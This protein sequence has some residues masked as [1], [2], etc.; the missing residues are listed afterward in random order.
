[1]RLTINRP[2]FAAAWQQVAPIARP[3]VKPILGNVLLDN[4]GR[5]SLTATDMET[6]VE[7]DI[8]GCITSRNAT[9]GKVL[10]PADR[11]AAVLREC[12]DT[13][14][15]LD[16][17]PGKGVRIKTSRSKFDFPTMAPDEFPSMPTLEQD[18]YHTVAARQLLGALKRTAFACDE[19]SAR[20]AFGGVL[21]EWRDEHI[22][23]VATD[24]RRLC[25]DRCPAQGHDH[26]PKATTIVPSNVVRSIMALLDTE[27]DATVRADSNRF[28]VSVGD[29][30]LTTRLLEGRFPRWTDV[31]PKH[32]ADPIPLPVGGLAGA[33]AQ[34]AICTT[35]D[36]RSVDFA[37]ADGKLTLSA[38]TADVGQSSVEL[39]VPWDRKP[40]TVCL[41]HRFVSDLLR[42]LPSSDNVLLSI[43][44][45][46]GPT[47]WRYGAAECVIMPLARE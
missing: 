45:A 47:L 38:T 31:V 13:E 2:K 9:C 4:N 15:T 8:D 33:I 29:T 44:D 28:A 11:V 23:L 10:L 3:G 18:G 6:A 37:F 7:A 43:E 35:K 27:G 19:D 5:S 21:I 42:V 30:L 24:G 17:E 46:D 26:E 41:D 22:D 16:V 1:M 32:N 40:L 14:I 39:I 12:T 20:Y 36:S 34:A 25:H